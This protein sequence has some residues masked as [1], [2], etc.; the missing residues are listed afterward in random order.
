MLG[1]KNHVETVLTERPDRVNA[2]GAHGI[3]LLTHAGLSGNI[4]LIEARGSWGRGK[5]LGRH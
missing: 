1:R 2:T 4:G 3:P 5:A